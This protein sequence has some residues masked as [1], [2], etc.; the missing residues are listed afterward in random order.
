MY[1]ALP[2]LASAVACLA[3][4]HAHQRGRID[5]EGNLIIGQRAR[6][7][8]LNSYRC[9]IFPIRVPPAG[10]GLGCDGNP[11]GSPVKGVHNC[12]GLFCAR[13]PRNAAAAELA[14]E[15]AREELAK[16]RESAA[17]ESL[18]AYGEL[19]N[20]YPVLLKAMYIRRL[21]GRELVTVPGFDLDKALSSLEAKAPAP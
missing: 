11:P 4:S 1:V 5:G 20:R 7:A 21:S 3:S 16:E 19:L 14:G 10:R 17:L 9:A 8:I 2:Y 12:L 6:T 13:G 18:A 15:R